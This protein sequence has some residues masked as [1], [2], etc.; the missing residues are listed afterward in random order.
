M[1][2]LYRIIFFNVVYVFQTIV[3]INMYA[4]GSPYVFTT[5]GQHFHSNNID[6]YMTYKNIVFERLPSGLDKKLQRAI[7]CPT[8]HYIVECMFRIEKSEN[9]QDYMRKCT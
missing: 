4:K 5:D 9:I 2:L 8:L 7:L 3:Y 6:I 1:S